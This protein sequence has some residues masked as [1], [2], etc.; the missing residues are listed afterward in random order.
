LNREQL[1]KAAPA[2]YS[3]G[4]HPAVTEHYQFLST[5]RVIEALRDLDWHPVRALQP[6]TRTPTGKHMVAFRNPT[7]RE[8]RGT[9]PELLLYNSHD[10]TSTFKFYAGAFRF[11][12]ANGLVVGDMVEAY[13]SFHLRDH[14]TLEDVIEAAKG[15]AIATLA[16]AASVE[17]MGRLKM[18]YREEMSFA[19]QAALLR[20]PGEKEA[21]DSDVRAVRLLTQRRFQDTEHDLWTVFNVVQENAVR[22]GIPMLAASGR[23]MITR[24]VRAIV[25]NLNLNRQLWK[26]AEDTAEYLKAA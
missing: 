26:L 10:R 7:A 6:A 23:A 16:K 18:T 8:V 24:P 1:E 5:E 2:I 11:V 22:G 9:V 19:R 3:L 15:A 20:W 21:Q 13:K 17:E 12:C 25:R 4:A 14:L